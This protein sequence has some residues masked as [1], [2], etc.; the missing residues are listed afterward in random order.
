MCG[1][2]GVCNLN[3]PEPISLDLLLSM[4]AAARHRGPDESGLFVDDWIGMGHAR[5][6]IIDL[7]GGTQPVHNEDQTVWIVFNGEIFNYVELRTELARQG[8]RFYTTSDTEVIVH[9]YEEEGAK[10]LQK[11]NGQFAFAVW[12]ARERKLLLARDRVGILPLHYAFHGDRLFF[13]SEIKSLFQNSEIP[14]EID[15]VALDEIFTFWTTLPGKTVF[16]NVCE[17]PAG[18]YLMLAG[19][20]PS[21]E[22]Y[23]KIPFSP[24]P[25]FQNGSKDQCVEEALDLITDA[26][27][28]RLRADVPVGCYLS[29]GLDSSGI[30]ALVKK[31]FNN[32]LRT[33]GI[34]FEEEAFDEGEFQKEMVSF[35][36]VDHQEV[37]AKNGS[38]ADL[39][40]EVLWH[41]E[42]PMLRTAPVP[43]FL[44][45][46]KVRDAGFKVVLTGEGADEIFGG[47][48]IFRETKVRRF[49]ARRPDSKIRPL[50]ISKLYPYILQNAKGQAFLKNFFGAGLDQTEN[51]LFS[52]MIRWNDTNR[53]KLFF[54]ED[55]KNEI[56]AYCAFEELKSMLPG[57]FRDW[58]C[59]P[60]AQY[61][62]I[63][64][65]MSNYLLSAQGDRVAMAHGV[66]VRPPYLDH[67]IIEFAGKIPPRWKIRGLNE[68]YILKQV[69]KNILPDGI[70]QRPKHP[71]R[72]PIREGLVNNSGAFLEQM[73]LTP[74]SL[75]EAGLFDPQKVQKLINKVRVNPSLSEVD[76]MALAGIASSQII[77]KRFVAGFPYKSSTLISPRLIV[78]R[79]ENNV[80]H[81][82]LRGASK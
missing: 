5:L 19:G 51:P 77:Y 7:A 27:R 3:S 45:S 67:R 62:E 23:W 74:R 33:F 81:R 73:N 38:I 44:L 13:S 66:E 57:E 6:S 9:L 18:H 80:N 29:G 39:F 60:K 48:N 55:L 61:L 2:A 50:L 82:E 71:Y 49:W 1:I 76:G 54:S 14:R 69:Y 37:E 24:D 30:T 11:L 8:H 35:L 59:L 22:Q 20:K 32:R 70:L 65:F 75:Q 26:I 78:D 31:N 72:A 36:G 4:T 17:L 28:I 63:L 21:M 10:C 12:D 15:P 58:N 41:C 34:R 68:K 16:R 47:Y 53:T 46:K 79:R 40:P 25:G 64:L 56:G 43:L 52:H 42:K